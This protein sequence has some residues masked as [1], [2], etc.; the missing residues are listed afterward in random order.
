M[1]LT[2]QLN[3]KYRALIAIKQYPICYLCGQPIKKQNEVSQDH[4][5][6]KALSGETVEENL[7]PTHRICNSKKGMMTVQQWFDRQ[8]E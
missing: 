7:A 8:R 6:P 1:G 3:R 4:L 5:I 2:S